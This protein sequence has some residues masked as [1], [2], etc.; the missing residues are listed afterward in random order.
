[1]L[2]GSL[3]GLSFIGGVGGAIALAEVPLPRPGSDPGQVRQYF[4]QNANAARLSAAGQ[5]ISGTALARFTAS[6]ARLT[7]RADP[8]SQA[9]QAT[10]A[11]VATPAACW[12]APAGPT[13]RQDS[14]AAILARQA[15][16]A[17]GVVH[18]IR[19]GALVGPLGLA[20]RRPGQ[21]PR[22][23]AI[24]GMT[25]AS[26]SLLS[27]LYL[28]AEPAGWLMPVGR[29]SGLIVRG[30][31]G[32]RLARGASV[33]SDQMGSDNPGAPAAA[34]EEEED[35]RDLSEKVALVTGSSQ[36]IGAAIATL[37]ADHGANVVLYGRDHEAWA[38]VQASIH[39]NTG[40][41]MSVT[42]DVHNP[43]DLEAMRV[44]IEAAFGERRRRHATC[45][46]D[47][48]IS[49]DRAG[50]GDRAGGP[51]ARGGRHRPARRRPRRP[52]RG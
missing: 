10:P 9:C 37:C 17:G 19:F 24:T 8:G 44:Q 25:A 5:G 21:L 50:A 46:R 35:V 4:T 43:A 3:V 20:G 26:V 27:P 41:G 7:R 13:G 39:G 34:P 31:P 45:S 22:R 29:F 15:F 23:L 28:A 32:V 30:A 6:V 11:S 47:R 40:Q 12:A 42:G 51:R 38:T 48:R 33:P 18:L 36:G 16:I 1:M 14:T 2:S 52:G 49:W